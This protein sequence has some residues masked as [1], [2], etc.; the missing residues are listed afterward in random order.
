MYFGSFIVKYLI[1]R[2]FFDKVLV[3]KQIDTYFNNMYYE[4]QHQRWQI[5][6]I[7]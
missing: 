5:K 3:A 6:R 2:Q 4:N 7:G 1:K